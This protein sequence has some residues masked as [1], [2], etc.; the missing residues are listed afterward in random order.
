MLASF[1]DRMQP[2]RFAGRQA[3]LQHI[4]GLGRP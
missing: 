4:R 1:D 2:D 3:S